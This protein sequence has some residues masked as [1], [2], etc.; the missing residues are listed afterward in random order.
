MFS[1]VE[2]F[3]VRRD[4]ACR[5]ARLRAIPAAYRGLLSINSSL[6]HVMDE[7][8]QVASRLH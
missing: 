5:E 1:D 4:E 2:D 8:G 3:E 6:V 7:D